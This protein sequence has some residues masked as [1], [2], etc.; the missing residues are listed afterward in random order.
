MIG[1]VE[2]IGADETEKNA[3]CPPQAIPDVPRDYVEVM[4]TELKTRMTWAQRPEL[5]AWMSNCRLD[6]YQAQFLTMPQECPQ[7]IPH[8][9]R[10]MAN[11][12]KALE[13]AKAL[14]AN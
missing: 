7:A 13:N 3:L 11:M 1:H 2:A 9:Q 8:F 14:L 4:R 5:G 6:I 12:G 10:Y